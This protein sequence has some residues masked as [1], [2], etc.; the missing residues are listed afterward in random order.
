[1]NNPYEDTSPEYHYSAHDV[2]IM[3]LVFLGSGIFCLI[4]CWLR[5]GL[6]YQQRAKILHEA[7]LEKQALW[8]GGS[9]KKGYGAIGRT[10]NPKK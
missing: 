8:L 2:P 5:G 9:K 3:F 4:V 10:K 1:M 7:D 6:P